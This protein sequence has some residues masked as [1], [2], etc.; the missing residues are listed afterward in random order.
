MTSLPPSETLD[1][2]AVGNFFKDTT[3]S[4]KYLL[5]LSLLKILNSRKFEVSYPIE[6]RELTIEMLVNAWY[7]YAYY[8][9]SLGSQD[10]IGEQLEAIGLG[11][12][13]LL[14]TLPKINPIE[15]RKT[16]AT[17]AL[18]EP[19]KTLMRFVPYRLIRPFFESELREKK[20]VKINPLIVELA[21]AEFESR[22]PLYWID[23]NGKA[24]FVH[25]EWANYINLHYNTLK[26]WAFW[27]WVDYMQRRNPK[28][29]DVGSKLLPPQME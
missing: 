10:T 13:Q 16:I 17:K 9:L 20:D 8:K 21:Q 12:S 1:I 19:I 2:S 25:P 22:K 18:E 15:L 29:S 27:E 3:N 7:P 4:Y 6:F 23:T 11:R 28:I 5:F 24:V 14:A 26:N